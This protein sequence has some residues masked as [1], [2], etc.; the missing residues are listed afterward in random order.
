MP[1]DMHVKLF[2]NFPRL[3]FKCYL[4]LNIYEFFGPLLVLA[5]TSLSFF[6]FKSRPFLSSGKNKK[7]SGV[8][9]SFI[10]TQ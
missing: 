4:A 8:P 3:L 5:Y 9:R 10:L 7:S 6:F 2:I 1:S